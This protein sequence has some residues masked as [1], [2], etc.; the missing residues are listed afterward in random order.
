M[1]LEIINEAAD[2]LEQRA[3]DLQMNVPHITLQLD[4]EGLGL[5]VR[6]LL[7]NALKFTREAPS[8]CIEIAARQTGTSVIVSVSDNGIG[9]DM[10]YHD[11]IFKLFNRLHRENQY[12][13]TGIG[14]ALVRKAI[15]RIGGRVWAESRE[16]QGATFYIEL[17]QAQTPASASA[18]QPQRASA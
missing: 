4:A 10:Q 18:S 3:I 7:Q 14:L 8:P 13:G 9:F 16:G 15:E 2:E 5:A 6:N 1:I 17:I 12:P 11:Q